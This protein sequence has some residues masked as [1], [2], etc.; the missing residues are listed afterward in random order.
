MYDPQTLLIVDE[1]FEDDFSEGDGLLGKVSLDEAFSL[2]A[3]NIQNLQNCS[4]SVLS[5]LDAIGSVHD[6]HH[7][8]KSLHQ[9]KNKAHSL[10]KTIHTQV[11]ELTNKI[12]QLKRTDETEELYTRHQKLSK[13]YDQ[14]LNQ[15]HELFNTLKERESKHPSDSINFNPTNFVQNL[16]DSLSSESAELIRQTEAEHDRE[17]HKQHQQLLLLE[18]GKEIQNEEDI[19]EV[20]KDLKELADIFEALSDSVIVQ[21]QKLQNA[22][23]LA[24]D[25]QNNT[26]KGTQDLQTAERWK[27]FGTLMGMTITGALIGAVVGGPIGVLVAVKSAV[28]FS[29]AIGSSTILGLG[30]GAVGG[31]VTKR[32]VNTKSSTSTS[33]QP[34]EA[35][36]TKNNEN[37]KM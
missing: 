25:A 27:S 1:H 16:N 4:Q 18:E 11:T 34:S 26:E 17:T 15:L 14:L 28:S 24:Q 36:P 8:R 5:L 22:L 3:R 10:S 13:D 2:L 32:Y 35:L 6:S 31:A 9:L 12:K 29:T 37:V 30:V 19:A 7:L 21:E 20:E 33:I 23:A